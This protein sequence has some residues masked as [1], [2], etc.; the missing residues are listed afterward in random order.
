[1]VFH[2]HQSSVSVDIWYILHRKTR[3]LFQATVSPAGGSESFSTKDQEPRFGWPAIMEIKS[4]AINKYWLTFIGKKF[5]VNVQNVLKISLSI[6]Q[7]TILTDLKC[8]DEYRTKIESI[9]SGVRIQ[10]PI[11]NLTHMNKDDEFRSHL[12]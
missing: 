2:L 6:T 5:N 8:D 10:P 4:K 3:M 11:P 7:T 12:H 1:M 9:S